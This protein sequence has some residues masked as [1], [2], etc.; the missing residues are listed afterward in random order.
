MVRDAMRRA[1]RIAFITGVIAACIPAAALAH[2]PYERLERVMMDDRGRE[3]RLVLSYTDGILGFDP[4]KLVVRD[5]D[6]RTIAETGTAR[7]ISVICARPPACVVFA[8]DDVSPLPGQIWW[9]NNGQLQATHSTWLTALGVV[10]PL[11]SDAWG[12]VVAVGF[13]LL[14]W[15]VLAFLWRIGGAESSVSTRS[16]ATLAL[17]VAVFVVGPV[18]TLVYY[19]SC[20]W[21]LGMVAE[22]SPMLA[23]GSAVLVGG[24]IA[25][26]LRA[27]R[28]PAS[29]ETS[30][31]GTSFA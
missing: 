30:E 13:L 24:W 3:L 19:F 6:N 7:T 21:I 22:L 16:L 27:G 5:H 15:P 20:F 28:A 26:S 25:L 4:V 1:G 18:G 12:Y 2:P 9:L 31:P 23:I 8:H 17:Q 10:A 11:W 14:P 29:T